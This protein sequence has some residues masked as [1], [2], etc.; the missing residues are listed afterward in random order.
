MF[1]I[2]C[3]GKRNVIVVRTN[4]ITEKLIVCIL[5][6]KLMLFVKNATNSLLVTNKNQVIVSL[7]VLFDLAI[8][9]L[10][11]TK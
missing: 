4:L 8:L 2:E 10:N 11:L 3:F 6:P 1:T 9:I 5:T 7:G